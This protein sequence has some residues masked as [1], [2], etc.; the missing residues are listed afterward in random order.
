[1]DI[2]QQFDFFMSQL[3]SMN[4]IQAVAFTL[5]FLFVWFLPTV[6][7]LF[8]NRRNLKVIFVANVPAIISWIVWFGLM[9]WAAT[10]KLTNKAAEQIK[11]SDGDIK[12]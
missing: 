12:Q 1:M 11:V 2:T 8:F 4:L 6:V 5:F 9:G 7:A 10:G 3:T